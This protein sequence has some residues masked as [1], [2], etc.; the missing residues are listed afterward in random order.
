MPYTHTI[1]CGGT[2]YDVTTQTHCDDYLSLNDW[3]MANQRAF[4]KIEIP[5]DKAARV[6][7]VF[8]PLR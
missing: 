2:R 4:D 1:E 6:K 8:K 5:P 3:I 7:M